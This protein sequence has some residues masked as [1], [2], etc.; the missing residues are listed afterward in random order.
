M[1][2]PAPATN[3]ATG[4]L[5]RRCGKG[6]AE[7]KDPMCCACRYGPGAGRAQGRT[8]TEHDAFEHMTIIPVG[9]RLFWAD[10]WLAS[11]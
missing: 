9:Y 4:H 6:V 10:D 11:I 1:T 3:A 8:R 5:C 2:S 7:Q